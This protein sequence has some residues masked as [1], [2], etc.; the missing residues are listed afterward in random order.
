MFPGVVRHNSA[1]IKSC[2]IRDL[3]SPVK[4]PNSASRM[5]GG[6]IMFQNAQAIKALADSD[7]TATADERKAVYAA[8]DSKI[9]KPKVIPVTPQAAADLI[10]CHK[11]TLRR[12]EKQGVL[13]PIRLTCR[14]IRYDRNDVERFLAEGCTSNNGGQ[15]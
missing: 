4:R 13:V 9:N 6:N 11:A 10:G 8:V 5:N 14:K 3:T 15:Q 12:W 2:R 1:K 7:P